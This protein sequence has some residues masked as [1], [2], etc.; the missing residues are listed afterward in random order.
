[1]T[2]TNALYKL[3]MLYMLSRVDFPLST[4]RLSFFLL[5]N[6][7]TDYFTLQQDLGE[8]LDDGYV[9]KEL[10]HGKTLYYLTDEGRT[11]LKLMKKEI[12]D[13]MCH[14]IDEYIKENRIPMHEDYAVQSHCYQ[15]DL[16]HYVSNLVI[17]EDGSK[18]LEINIASSTQ[19]MAEQICANWKEQSEAV[20]PM[21][22]STLMKK[23]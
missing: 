20:Y 16:T 15:L 4:N 12:S 17:E 22:L 9:E 19:N 23:K 11:V 7:Y 2:E 21:L 18:L 3:S 6:N 10:V 5:S 14:D 1:M 8:L 13:S